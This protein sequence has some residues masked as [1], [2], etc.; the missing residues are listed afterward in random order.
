MW[1]YSIYLLDGLDGMEISAWGDSVIQYYIQTFIRF[2]CFLGSADLECRLPFHV[3]RLLQ[4]IASTTY[5]TFLDTVVL[6]NCSFLE[7]ILIALEGHLHKIC[8]IISILNLAKVC[9]AQGRHL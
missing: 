5:I 7:Y 3:V 4:P 9:F 1:I 8:L 2:F 6:S